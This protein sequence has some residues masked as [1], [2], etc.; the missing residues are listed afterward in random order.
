MILMCR[1]AALVAIFFLA[2]HAGAATCFDIAGERHGVAPKLLYVIAQ[3][4]SAMNPRAINRNKDGSIDIGLMQINSRWLPSL[5][6]YGISS[7]ALF[8]PCT[9]ADVGAW[10]LAANF[11]RYGVNWMGLG[12][13]NAR[14]LHL[15]E[16]YAK[17][18]AAKLK[19]LS[20]PPLMAVCQGQVTLEGVSAC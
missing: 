14:N 18:I 19:P 8:D 17:N 16:R 4:E 10:I 11:R 2:G 13:Y 20:P 1:F 7:E 12:A 9:S 15:R 5:A 3:H 6:R